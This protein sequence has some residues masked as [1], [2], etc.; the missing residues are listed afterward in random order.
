M[1]KDQEKKSAAAAVHSLCAASRIFRCIPGKLRKE[2]VAGC[3]FVKELFAYCINASQI[4][5]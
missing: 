2:E 1:L 3:E 5:V 4:T